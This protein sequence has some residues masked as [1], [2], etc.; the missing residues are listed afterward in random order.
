MIHLCVRNVPFL[1]LT[2]AVIKVRQQLYEEGDGRGGKEIVKE[3][4]F[5]A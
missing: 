4:T 3:T 1:S 2:F 5:L